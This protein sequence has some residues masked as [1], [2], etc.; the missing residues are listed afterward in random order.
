MRSSVVAH[1]GM[2]RSRTLSECLSK[3][4]T[5]SRG[6]RIALPGK[7]HA[8]WLPGGRPQQGATRP[9]CSCRGA[10]EAGSRGGQPR[11]PAGEDVSG[12][13]VSGW[14]DCTTDGRGGSHAHPSGH[15]HAKDNFGEGSTLSGSF[16]EAAA[17]PTSGHL[18]VAAVQL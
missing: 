13:R 6:C 2:W 16:A 15:F 1:L 10:G 9:L 12:G 7:L 14:R 18:Q 11:R 3:L 4:L 5:F 8:M 17:H